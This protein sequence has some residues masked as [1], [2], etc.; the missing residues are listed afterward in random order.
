[1]FCVINYFS[2]SGKIDSVTT[3]SV[4]CCYEKYRIIILQL[5]PFGLKVCNS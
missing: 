5:L 2:K 3:I 1:M 4:M